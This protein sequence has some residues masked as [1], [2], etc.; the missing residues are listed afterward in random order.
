VEKPVAPIGDAMSQSKY[1][2][3]PKARTVNVELKFEGRCD[4]LK[5]YTFNYSDGCQSDKY[6]ATMKKLAEYVNREYT[7]G[8][9]I[10]WMIKNE[11]C[12]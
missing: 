5:G 9:D 2:I 1:S 8:G 3:R 11:K 12:F 6:H 10:S 7:Y 4:G